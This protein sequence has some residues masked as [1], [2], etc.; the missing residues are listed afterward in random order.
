MPHNGFHNEGAAEGHPPCVEAFEG[1]VP[2]WM[3]LAGVY[4]AS[5]KQQASGGAAEGPPPC[6]EAFEGRVPLRMGLASDQAP[7]S[8]QQASTKHHATRITQQ[9]LR[10]SGSKTLAR[11]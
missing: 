4:A 9:A 2:L 6:V 11:N 7:S 8:K 10:K 3:D 5:S 1:R